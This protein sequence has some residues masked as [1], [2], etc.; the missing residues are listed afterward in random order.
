ME[1]R[2]ISEQSFMI[3]FNPEINEYTFN[4]VNAMK[5]YINSLEH[6]FI[7]ELL[8]SYRAILVYFDGIEIKYESLI[9]ELKLNEFHFENMQGQSQ[10]K[11]I[12]IPVLYGGEWGPDLDLVAEHNK[13][14]PEEVVRKHTES[15]YLVYMIGFMPG[16]PFL[17]GLDKALHTPRKAEPRLK[18]PAGSVGIAN[19]QTGLYPE[20]SPGGWQIIGQTPIKVFDLNRDPKILYQPG[21]KIKFYAINEEQFLHIKKYTAKV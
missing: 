3:Y 19:N 13:L 7:K 6:P 1:C 10:R 21:D 11:I 17:G 14:T 15:F 8:P 12:N 18:I 2:Q 5:D 20:D 16:F 4:Q 9:E